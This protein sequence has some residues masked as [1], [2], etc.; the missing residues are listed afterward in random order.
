MQTLR[1]L[2]HCSGLSEQREKQLLCWNRTTVPRR[3]HLKLN[4]EFT[5]VNERFPLTFLLYFYIGYST[6]ESDVF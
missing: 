4:S 5:K 1:E 6:A 2:K 3:K